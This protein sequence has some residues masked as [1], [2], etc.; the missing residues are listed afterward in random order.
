MKRLLI[1]LSIFVFVLIHG[2]LW[3]SQVQA[4]DEA[5]P[6][7]LKR[8]NKLYQEKYNREQFDLTDIN[9]DGY[10][11]LDELANRPGLDRRVFL[12]CR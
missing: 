11:D 10:L 12:W 3:V 8:G 5:V 6:S 7:Y 4:D 2:F 9:G 1:V